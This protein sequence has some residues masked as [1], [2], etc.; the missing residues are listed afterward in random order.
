MAKKSDTSTATRVKASSTTAKSK[1]TI[2]S[3]AKAAKAA[4][5]VA[6]TTPAATIADEAPEKRN[7]LRSFFGYFAGA[8]YE[9]KQ[10]RWP[11]RKATWGLTLAVLLFSLFFVV[12]ILLLDAGFK[13]LFEQLLK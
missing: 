7:I 10:V 4:N 1:K 8:W 2:G 13:Y 12:F 6:K 5:K 9:L 3:K 11:T